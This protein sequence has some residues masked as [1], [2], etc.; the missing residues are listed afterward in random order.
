MPKLV[1]HSYQRQALA[2]LRR[3]GILPSTLLFAGPVGTGKRQVALELA[4][5]LLCESQESDTACDNCKSC[6]LSRVGNHPDLLTVE[7][8][9]REVW[10]TTEVR[11]LLS[12]LQLHPY[13]GG[14]R[15]LILNDAD[16][17]TDQAA[18]ALLKTL[19]EPFPGNY[20]ILVS[21][22]PSKLPSPI[23]SRCQ[24][25]NFEGLNPEELAEV[26]NHLLEQKAEIREKLLEVPAD[27]QKQILRFA[28]GS[29]QTFLELCAQ[30]PEVQNM[31]KALDSMCTGDLPAA[32]KFA[33]GLAKERESL[34]SKLHIVRSLA[35][36]QL[37]ECADPS[38]RQRYAYLLSNVLEAERAIFERNLSAQ[39]VLSHVFLAFSNPQRL[40]APG[41]D[42][43]LLQS[44]IL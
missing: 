32:I 33:S 42:A 12:S 8:A 43:S 44:L 39:L 22:N 28:D 41:A 18:N 13:M 37:H 35:R 31:V 30:L 16:A 6:S 34:P 9:N 2:R 14:K 19:E 11:H 40:S 5:A 4:R 27:R 17:M 25:W 3:R 29:V 23:L 10:D 15:V 21:A 36:T 26:V 1:G 24:R 38:L 20:F 7:S